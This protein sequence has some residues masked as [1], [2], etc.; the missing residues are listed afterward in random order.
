MP[1]YTTKQL[2]MLKMPGYPG[3]PQGWDKL[4]KTQNWPFIETSGR[5][6][7]GVR[8]EYSPPPSVQTLIDSLP[9]VADGGTPNSSHGTIT[10]PDGTC[11]PQP[12]TVAINETRQTERSRFLTWITFELLKIED[13]CELPRDEKLAVPERIVQI[14]MATGGVESSYPLLM[15]FP[16]LVQM[17]FKLWSSYENMREQNSDAS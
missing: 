3:T 11:R 8:R 4:V 2:A 15:H 6:R 16:D 10:E 5:G 13:F 17:A 14:L 12:S 9:S 1:T 7:G